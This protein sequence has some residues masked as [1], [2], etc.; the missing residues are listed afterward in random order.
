MKISKSKIKQTS[1]LVKSK[2]NKPSK[3]LNTIQSTRRDPSSIPVT[4]I[5]KA[6]NTKS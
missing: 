5:P 4:K 1:K 6:L 3:S 2:V